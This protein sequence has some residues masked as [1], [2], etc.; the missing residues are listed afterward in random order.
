MPKNEEDWRCFS[1][2]AMIVELRLARASKSGPKRK[3][4]NKGYIHYWTGTFFQKYFF[5]RDGIAWSVWSFIQ[6][7]QPG[8]SYKIT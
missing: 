1:R 2:M 4:G 3:D 6:K 8:N 7:E 5:I